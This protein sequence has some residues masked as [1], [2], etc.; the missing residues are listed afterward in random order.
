MKKPMIM[1]AVLDVLLFAGCGQI[2]YTSASAP[3]SNNEELAV[4]VAEQKLQDYRLLKLH[5]MK[6]QL[7][8]RK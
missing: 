6:N 4:I 2:E 3:D 5:L 7:K 1:I 8:Q